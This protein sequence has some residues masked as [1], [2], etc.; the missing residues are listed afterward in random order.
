MGVVFIR[1]MFN[2]MGGDSNVNCLCVFLD[3]IKNARR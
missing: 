2:N 1:V 3:R